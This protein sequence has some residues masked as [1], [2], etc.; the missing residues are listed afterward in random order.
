MSQPSSAPAE[1]YGGFHKADTL[2]NRGTWR[3]RRKD[4]SV[5]PV[6][7][8]AGRI[9]YAGQ[10]ERLI[11]ALDISARVKAEHDVQEHLYTQQRAA[12]AAQAIP[13]HPTLEG[14]LQ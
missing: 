2:R 12:D 5:F 1:N 8:V 10:D 13:W 4:G 6:D 14:S 9:Q 7:I 11:V 3:H